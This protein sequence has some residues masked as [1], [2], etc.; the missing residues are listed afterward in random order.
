MHTSVQ[1]ASDLLQIDMF[2]LVREGNVASDNERTGDARQ[3]GGQ[4]LRPAID[5][6]FPLSATAETEIEIRCWGCHRRA[7]M[8][9]MLLPTLFSF[10]WCPG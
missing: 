2:Y 1:L 7:A 3:V 9:A 10:I 8:R 4:A 6:V 5:E